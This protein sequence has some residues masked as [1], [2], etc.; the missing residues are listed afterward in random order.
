M[1][2]WYRFAIATHIQVKLLW[3]GEWEKYC[4]KNA[5]SWC[6]APCTGDRLDVLLVSGKKSFMASDIESTVSEMISDEEHH[7]DFPA[8]EQHNGPDGSTYAF[9]PDTI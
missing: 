3:T 2:F 5:D 1:S 6:H 8:K 9:P 4:W 7:G